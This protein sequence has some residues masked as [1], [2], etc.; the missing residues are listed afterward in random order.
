MATCGSCDCGND[1]Y[2]VHIGCSTR[3]FMTC[4]HDKNEKIRSLEY[5]LDFVKSALF[6]AET[7]IEKANNKLA[8]LKRDNDRQR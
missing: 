7:I 8:E 3:M 4:A 1:L 5:E 6:E 2:R